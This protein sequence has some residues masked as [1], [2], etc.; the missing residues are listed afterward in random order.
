MNQTY[1]VPIQK[2]RAL[3]YSVTWLIA[4]MQ[5]IF[6]LKPYW[7]EDIIIF[8]ANFHQS[9]LKFFFVKI[10]PNKLNK[11]IS[12]TTASQ[13]EEVWTIAPKYTGT[14]GSR[15]KQKQKELVSWEYL[16]KQKNCNDTFWLKLSGLLRNSNRKIKP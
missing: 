7:A 12:Q 13:K 8:T 4:S 16:K 5:D 2:I 1:P 6:G 14:Q 11:L 3:I 10:F 15:E 9:F